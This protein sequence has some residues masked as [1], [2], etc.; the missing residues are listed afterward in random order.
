MPLRADIVTGET[1]LHAVD[2]RLPGYLPLA[3]ARSYRS[4]DDRPGPFGRGWRF[5][6]DGTLEIGAEEWTYGAGSPRETIFTPID[7]GRQARHAT[8]LTLEHHPDAYVVYA[9]PRCRQVFPKRAGRRGL[10]RI[11][12]LEDSG[13]HHVQFFYQGDR[14]TGLTD[15]L[16]RRILFAYSGARV[17]A[18]RVVEAGT[19]ASVTVRS[20]RYDG[21]GRL[22]RVTD[23]SGR[24]AAL[25]YRKHLLVTYT[26]P[27]GGVCH[28][29]YD[30]EGRCHALWQGD[31][32]AARRLFYDS[33]RQTTRVV[34][35]DGKQA[36]Y[37]HV[38]GRQ[39]LEQIDPAGDPQNY[40]W[41]ERQRLIGFSDEQGG[42]TTFQRLDPD[43]NTLTLLDGEER[44]A[45]CEVNEHAL[46]TS[47]ADAFENRYVL[48]YDAHHRPVRLTTPSEAVWT[49]ERDRRGAVTAVA[50]PEER[51][52]RLIRSGDGR[53]L[54]V[55]DEVGCCYE[56][57]CDGQGRL[58]ECTDALGRRERRQYDA[59]GRLTDLRLAEGYA[60]QM[61]YDAA[62]CPTRIA[63]SEQGDWSFQYDRFGRL[64]RRTGPEGK[65]L[66]LQ[67][68]AEGRI[69]AATGAQ[70]R[71]ARFAY[72]GYGRLVESA[73]LDGSIVRCRYGEDGVEVSI[74]REDGE[75]IRTYNALGDPVAEVLS[76]GTERRFDYGPSG[77][78]LAV[79]AEERSAYFGYDA[80]GRIVSVDAGEAVLSFSYDREGNLLA[81][82]D[83]ADRRVGFRYDARSRLAAVRH[84]EASW[85]FTYDA[86]DR[87]TALRLPSGGQYT[88]GYDGLDRLTE[89]R[90]LD[91]AG[92]VLDRKTLAPSRD[93]KPWTE[94][95]HPP[96]EDAEAE[97]V[98]L[99][100]YQSR[101]V[102]ALLVSWGGLRLPVWMQQDALRGRCAGWTPRAVTAVVRGAEALWDTPR[103]GGRE[104]LR[105]WN[106]AS[107]QDLTA[108]PR[109]EAV[110][111]AWRVLDLFFLAPSFY[112]ASFPQG[113]ASH[114]AHH[115]ADPRRALDPMLTGRHMTE[116]LRPASW[117]SRAAG[118][119][120][121]RG[122]FVP[123]RGGL[124]P[125]DVLHFFSLPE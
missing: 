88:F 57:R 46:V 59:A 118:P 44:V 102:R 69:T 24:S 3:L 27:L 67:Y 33:L 112:E 6:L 94:R 30:D 13:N 68:D 106:R 50:S 7:V 113:A 98:G 77:E 42:V 15:T 71:S 41:D 73:G 56:A 100:L 9:S 29:Q 105:R 31:G 97:P 65:R 58:V 76:G 16:G 122:R 10:L 111:P 55:E 123:R 124:R 104:R 72:D 101:H 52:V 1:V 21:R 12:R 61:R 60:L 28:A 103:A 34:G 19:E 66:Q 85:H 38:G 63:D 114:A 45:L 78:L 95:L 18:L 125:E 39:V 107:E 92:A 37:R 53:T 47:V 14:L 80:E 89:R 20:F 49:F 48:E 108:L 84:A 119:H 87:L 36:I 116:A 64:L 51:R 86:G 23:A 43:E 25:A 110:R 70:G 75:T 90:R 82:E 93:G 109:S 99:D 74:R 96:S 117:A 120:L 62:G 4:G 83:D 79:E 11:A 22:V 40:Y 54:T 17:T 121:R 32:S 26:N 2:L 115:R 81:V 8:G 91:A 5:S 35:S